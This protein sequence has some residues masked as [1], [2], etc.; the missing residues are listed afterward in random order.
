MVMV[1]VG[2]YIA[3]KYVFK[4]SF[5]DVGWNWGSPK[6]YAAA[7]GLPIL[8]WIVPSLIE[9]SLGT[10]II[11]S[12]FNILSALSTFVISFII[13][14]VPAFGEEFGWRGY[15]LPRLLNQ[16]SV[17]NALLIQAFIWWIW[18]L[19]VIVFS[20]INTPL[21]AG[22]VFLSTILVLL[23]SILP[24]VMHAVI[25]AYF[26]SASY[27]IAVATVYHSAFDE[28]RDT[29][30]CTIGYGNMVNIWQMILLTIL[31]G[32]LRARII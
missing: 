20:G 28:V 10:R 12:N 3:G 16:Y 4:D 11:L 15:L 13:T 23:I 18:H 19:P 5:S 29:I 1:T 32:V 22:N 7:F 17:R 2:T 21:N 8:L 30:E 9:I 14:L 6:H 26:W 24:S 25:F 31:G 27:S